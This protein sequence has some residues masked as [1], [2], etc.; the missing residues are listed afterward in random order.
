MRFPITS[1]TYSTEPPKRSA[2]SAPSTIFANA[3]LNFKQQSLQLEGQVIDD[4]YTLNT[5][6]APAR[7]PE[8]APR[9]FSRQCQPAQRKFE[10]GLIAEV[11]ALRSLQGEL[12]AAESSFAQADG[13]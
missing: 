1:T 13:H 5:A 3:D 7:D 6:T 12:T 11:E 10:V 4:Y 2:C 9:S 8:T